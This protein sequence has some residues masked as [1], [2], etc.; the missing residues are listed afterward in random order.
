[1]TIFPLPIFERDEDPAY[2]D[3]LTDAEA[4]ARLKPPSSIVV[5]FG[6]MKL[7]GEYPYDGDAKPGCGS[8]LVVRT[9]RGTE[10]AE[11]LTST[12]PNSG[13]S[14]SVSR[15]EM[16][17]YV[18]NSGGKDYPFH[19]QGRVLRVATPED[20]TAWTTLRERFR[21]EELAAV[22]TRA[23]AMGMTMKIVEV[24]PVLGGEYVAVH[25]LSEERV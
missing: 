10:L 11:M 17:E 13:C 4:Y 23:A 6:S 8:K 12:C 1:M 5:R 24:E 9:H 22:R 2:R 15:R 20:L 3:A 19:T 18:E 7:V 25:Y 14:K 21:K 16:L